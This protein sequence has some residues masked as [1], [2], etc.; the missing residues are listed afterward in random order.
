MHQIMILAGPRGQN[1]SSTIIFMLLAGRISSLHM[2][3]ETRKN[4]GRASAPSEPALLLANVANPQNDVSRCLTGLTY[5]PKHQKSHFCH[6]VHPLWSLYLHPLGTQHVDSVLLGT[7]FSR[8]W[9]DLTHTL[10]AV[11]LCTAATAHSFCHP[12]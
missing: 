8:S 10:S 12:L 11:E 9:S 2:C 5:L 7:F 3:I 4:P 1:T 6:F